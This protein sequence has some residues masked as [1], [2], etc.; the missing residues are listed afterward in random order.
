MQAVKKGYGLQDEKCCGIKGGGQEMAAM[1][2]M[3]II[4]M[5]TR[6]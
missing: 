5:I 2:L 4:L 1:M 3:S 6:H